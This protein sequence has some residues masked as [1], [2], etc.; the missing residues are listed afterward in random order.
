MPPGIYFSE[1]PSEVSLEEAVD[2]VL[3]LN[4][5]IVTEFIEL[6]PQAEKWKKWLSLHGS[7]PER[8]VEKYPKHPALKYV[9]ELLKK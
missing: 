8:F 6:S 5:E 7:T 3:G 1:V 2:K 4:E 9:E